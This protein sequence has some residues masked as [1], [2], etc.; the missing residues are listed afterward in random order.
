[1]NKSIF[2]TGKINSNDQL[3]FL[4]F[5]FQAIEANYLKR[6]DFLI[7]DNCNVR[8]H[9]GIETFSVLDGLLKFVGI[10]LVYL[11]AYSPELNPNI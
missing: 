10:Q 5:V 3:G 8:I 4:K 11:P 2:I 9:G 7:C 1:M 6:G